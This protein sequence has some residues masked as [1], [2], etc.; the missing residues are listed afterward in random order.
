LSQCWSIKNGSLNIVK[1]FTWDTK[2]VSMA[3]I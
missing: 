2:T 1:P 3:G